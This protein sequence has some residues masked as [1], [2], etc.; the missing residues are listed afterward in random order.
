MSLQGAAGRAR[1]WKPS[2]LQQ[3][4]CSDSVVVYPLCRKRYI[5]NTVWFTRGALFTSTAQPQWGTS[6]MCVCVRQ[7][8]RISATEISSVGSPNIFPLPLRPR[9]NFSC[10]GGKYLYSSSVLKYSFELLVH[11]LVLFT[12]LY[13]SDSFS[14]QLYFNLQNNLKHIIS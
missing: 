5:G 10:S 11:N 4:M 14:Y 6:S 3:L 13:L 1:V 8:F 9:H 12:P 7:R 2:R